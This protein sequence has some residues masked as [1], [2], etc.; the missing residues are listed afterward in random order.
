MP[1]FP[2]TP[3]SGRSFRFK[4]LVTVLSIAI[5]AGSFLLTFALL[6]GSQTN[7]LKVST[8]GTKKK[9]QVPIITKTVP[10]LQ[11]TAGKDYG[12]RYAKGV[13]PVG[14]GKYSTASAKKGSVYTCATYAQNLQQTQGGAGTRGPW[15]SADGK[16]YDITKKVHVSGKVTWIPQF[17]E[18][19]SG[20]K[21]TIVTNDLPSHPTGVFPIASSDPAYLYDRNPN[22]IKAQS[23]TF[24]LPASPTYGTP[25][26]MGGEAG[27]MLS[28]V[29]LFNGFDAGGR[30]A[31]AWEVQDDCS[32][33]PQKEGEYHYHTLSSCI[34]DISTSKIIGYALDGFPITGPKISANNI[35]TTADLDECHG[36]FSPLIVNGKSTL[37]Y[38]YVMTQD[39]PYSVSCFRS[40]ATQAKDPNHSGLP[41]MQP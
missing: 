14:D 8:S 30:D 2:P 13:L 27:I 18:T 20:N 10:G 41:P 5:V 7:P 39:F 35:L 3:K 9:T 4:L 36:I 1:T 21:R 17:S 22:S 16:T 24:N 28:G 34:G 12:N 23:L 37:S 33:H 32:G 40:A 6:S 29:A 25:Q 38:H 15:F 11:L 26:C 31:G 19:L